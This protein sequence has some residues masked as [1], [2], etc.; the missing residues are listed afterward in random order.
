MDGSIIARCRSWEVVV[1]LVVACVVS[2]TLGNCA[3]HRRC[4]GSD[5]KA[6]KGGGWYVLVVVVRYKLEPREHFRNMD[7]FPRLIMGL[8]RLNG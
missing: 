7:V 6:L 2:T 3:S 8:C 4:G 5:S 1:D